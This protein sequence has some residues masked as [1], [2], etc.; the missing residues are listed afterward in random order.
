MQE[1]TSVHACIAIQTSDMTMNKTLLAC[2][3]AGSV[4]I[5]VAG[6]SED[7]PT[8]TVEGGQVLT[9]KTGDSFKYEAYDRDTNNV[10]IDTSKKVKVWTVLDTNLSIYSQTHVTRILQTNYDAAGTTQDP[11]HPTDTLYMK[12]NG[13]GQVFQYDALG[14]MVGRIQA[15][16]SFAP[17]V[18]KQWVQIADTK[19]AAVISSTSATQFDANVS[20][21]PVTIH[22]SMSGN[23]TGKQPVLLHMANN[24]DT[25]FANSFHADH[26]LKVLADQTG[27]AQ[28]LSDSIKVHYDVEVNGGLLKQTIDSKTVTLTTGFGNIV[29]PVTGFE[30]VLVS[31]TRK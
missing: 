7:T 12:V 24:K 3:L 15:A 10:R 9:F 23:S 8:Q 11:I 25:T 18:P 6:C 2:L 19:G 17:S 20:G 26:S 13:E 5:G 1:I 28:I 30:M 21:L 16:A 27:G 4:L 14:A 29:Q 22:L 31:Y